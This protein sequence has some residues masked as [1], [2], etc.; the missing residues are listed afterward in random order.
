MLPGILGWEAIKLRTQGC[1][2]FAGIF[3]QVSL[4]LTPSQFTGNV[5]V[6]LKAVVLPVLIIL[7]WNMV[8]PSTVMM[9]GKGNA[10]LNV[11]TGAAVTVMPSV[12][13][14]VLVPAIN[15]KVP[16][17]VEV[18]AVVKVNEQLAL[19]AKGE[20]QLPLTVMPRPGFWVTPTLKAS[21]IPIF[22]M[23]T[24]WL[25]PPAAILKAAGFALSF[26]TAIPTDTETA[27]VLVP[28]IGIFVGTKEGALAVNVIVQVP[29]G[30]T[31]VQL[32]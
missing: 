11:V 19:T 31:K 17:V 27:L 3:P 29:P 12:S 15:A 30:A 32:V 5:K 8:V 25:A 7:T 6:A 1:A 21:T 9:A 13:T 22:V 18:A 2:G 14:V 24:T 4:V 20:G 26:A 16:P 23:V 10:M 28:W